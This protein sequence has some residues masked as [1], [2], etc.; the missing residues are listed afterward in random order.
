MEN[1]TIIIKSQKSAGTAAL[2]GIFFGPLG[3]LYSTIT[4]AVVMFFVTGIVAFFTVGFGLILT[5]PICAIW[6]YSAA[7][8]ENNTVASVAVNAKQTPTKKSQPEQKNND[9]LFD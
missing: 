9:N 3:M 2:L 8:K 6:A 7:K 4:G 5:Q 1:Q